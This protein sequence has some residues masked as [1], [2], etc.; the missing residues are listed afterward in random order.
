[1][2]EL[3]AAVLWSQLQVSPP[4]RKILENHTC[5]PTDVAAVHLADVF[6]LLSSYDIWHFS[7]FILPFADLVDTADTS[8]HSLCVD[9]ELHRTWSLHSAVKKSLE[10]LKAGSRQPPPEPRPLPQ[11]QAKGQCWWA[12]FRKLLLLGRLGIGGITYY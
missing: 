5:S 11:Q 1:M 2:L 7:F 10:L 8:S 12:S 4:S 9:T 3:A 6:L